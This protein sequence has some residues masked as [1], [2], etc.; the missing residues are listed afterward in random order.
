MLK[1]TDEELFYDPNM[2]AEDEKWVERQRQAY[3]NG[4][5]WALIGIVQSIFGQ[6]GIFVCN[7]YLRNTCIIIIAIMYMHNM[8]IHV[9][10]HVCAY[11]LICLFIALPLFPSSCCCW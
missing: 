2:D 11:M 6:L 9:H 1:L 8:H 10:V 3:H 7:Y 5:C 4:T